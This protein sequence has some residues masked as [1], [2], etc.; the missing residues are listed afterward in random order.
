MGNPDEIWNNI[1]ANVQAAPT[2]VGLGAEVIAALQSIS[3]DSGTI[4]DAKGS[5]N[6]RTHGI[7][8][9]TLTDECVEGDE[10]AFGCYCISCEVTQ[11]ET[12]TLKEDAPQ[13]T[14]N[15]IMRICEMRGPHD[16]KGNK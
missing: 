1:K 9:V 3:T 11:H 12:M 16:R 6:F 8:F 2:G 15:D 5:N 14:R 10:D 4:I 7:S 13:M